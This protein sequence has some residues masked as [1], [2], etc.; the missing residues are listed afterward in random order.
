M[1]K[2]HMQDM[3]GKKIVSI[4]G[5]EAGSEVITIQFEG[6]KAQFWHDQDF[7][8]QVMFQK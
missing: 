1:K 3:I 8:E 6:Y 5:C 2:L 7:C 4:E